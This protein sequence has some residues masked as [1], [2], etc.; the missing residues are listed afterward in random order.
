MDTANLG[1]G[2]RLVWELFEIGWNRRDPSIA[3]RLCSET[4]SLHFGAIDLRMR[5]PQALAVP[6]R[7]VA[8]FPDIHFELLDAVE[9]E[10]RVALRLAFGGTHEGPFQGFPATHRE[11]RVTQMVFA[12]VE[13]GRVVELWEDYDALGMWQ[14]LGRKLPD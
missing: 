2:A 12:R 11:I 14:Q 5:S 1:A 4:C 7:W 10:G 13:A 6:L 8:A 3:D 9:A